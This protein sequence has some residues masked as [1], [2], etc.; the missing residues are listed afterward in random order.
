[1]A[2]KLFQIIDWAKK[3]GEVKAVDRIKIRAL[4]ALMAENIQIQNITESTDCSGGCLEAIRK[5]ASEVVGK[6]CP[7]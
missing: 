2:T 6:P 3:N 5:A 1:M 7:F 4:S